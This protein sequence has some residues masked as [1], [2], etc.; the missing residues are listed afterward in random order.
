MSE[1]LDFAQF[2]NR[3]HLTGA[4]VLDTGIR[5][6]AG[7]EDSILG[8][9]ISVV[10]DAWARPFIPGSSLKGI[11]RAEVERLARTI[12]LRSPK[13]ADGQQ[14]VWACL[15]PLDMRQGLCV[16]A[17]R[18][19]ELA[20]DA[21]RSDGL[22]DENKFTKSIAQESCPVCRLFGSPW[23]AGK[24]R[25][26]DLPIDEKTWAGRVEVRDGVG[27]RRDTHTAAKNVLYSHEVVPA[28]AH[29]KIQ[30]LIENANDVELGLAML[31][32]RELQQGRLSIGGTSSRG[33]GRI[34]LEPWE[35]IE[36]VNGADTDGL[37]DYLANGKGKEL[38]QDDLD[39]YIIDLVNKLRSNGEVSKSVP[40]ST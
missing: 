35:T 36:F 17:T 16:S 23:L 13:D 14:L 40:T 4:L 2:Y 38:V 7:S 1:Y 24:L 27:I 6:G 9:D 21:T 3:L 10:R 32:L 39:Q 8:A 18:K 19:E 15:N 26:R 12:A 11:L 22:V 29:F 28:G 31:G 37:L 30:I 34:R 25:V 20:K 5:I 33:L